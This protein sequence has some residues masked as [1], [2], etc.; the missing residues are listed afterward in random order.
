MPGLGAAVQDFHLRLIRGVSPDDLWALGDYQRFRKV[1]STSG[2]HWVPLRWEECLLH[3]DGRGWSLAPWPMSQFATNPRDRIA[4][5]DLA[6][7]PDGSL[8]CTGNRWHGP[9]NS[10]DLRVPV[11]A[12]PAGRAL[13]GHGRLEDARATRRLAAAAAQVDLAD[14]SAGRLGRRPLRRRPVTCHCLALGRPNLARPGL[15]AGR[16]A[17][18][19]ARALTGPSDVCGLLS[20]LQHMSGS[21][22]RRES[23]LQHFDGAAFQ[24]RRPRHESPVQRRVTMRRRTWI[25]FAGVTGIAIVAAV[26]FA[27][28]AHSTTSGPPAWLVTQAQQVAATSEDPCPPPRPTA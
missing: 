4:I 2:S 5:E 8:W 28:T 14:L 1:T 19:R 7:A 22:L 18:G 20:M 11:V 10:G 23:L 27:T 12:A 15:Q 25:Y 16:P 17:G 26:A 21:V 6:V 24:A 3:W 9:D 13:A